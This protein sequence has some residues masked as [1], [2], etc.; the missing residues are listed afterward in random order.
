MAY[1][2]VMTWELGIALAGRA[3]LEWMVGVIADFRRLS[4]DAVRCV[5]FECPNQSPTNVRTIKKTPT[6][7]FG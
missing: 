7:R 3:P 5:F 2:V 1:S 4:Y 6:T